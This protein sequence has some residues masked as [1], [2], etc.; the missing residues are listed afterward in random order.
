MSSGRPFT[1]PVRPSWL[2]KIFRMRLVTSGF[3]NRKLVVRLSASGDHD[4]GTKM[5]ASSLVHDVPQSMKNDDAPPER[6]H[7][8]AQSSCTG[9]KCP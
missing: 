1:R 4:A 6:S 9:G 5:H 8:R 3:C 7:M 2:L